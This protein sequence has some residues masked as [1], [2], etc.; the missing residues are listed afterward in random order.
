MS[1]EV[2][3]DGLKIASEMDFHRE[4][5]KAMRFLE[6]YGNNLDALWDVLSG[7]LPEQT[8]LVW[9]N[10]A[11][12]RTMLGPR[13]EAIVSVLKQAVGC[14]V[15]REGQCKEARTCIATRRSRSV[16]PLTPAL[17]PLRGEGVA[18]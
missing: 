16:T 9:C 4:V 7:D 1:K 3:I 11:R 13:F 14:W 2:F 5:A 6:Y 10:A 15:F 17:S 8:T 12:S 18:R